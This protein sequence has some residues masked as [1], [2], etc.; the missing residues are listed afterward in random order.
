MKPALLPRGGMLCLTTDG[1]IQ[2]GAPPET[3]KDSIGSPTGVAHTFVLTRKFFDY[4][5]GMAFAEVEF[6]IYWNFFCQRRRA[7]LVCTPEQ[8]D[9][10]CAVMQESLFGP[11]H[12]D[13]RPELPAG[14]DAFDWMPDL[15][16][17]LAYFRRN[18]FSGEAL[19]LAD[20]VDFVLFDGESGQAAFDGVLVTAKDDGSYEVLDAA[21]KLRA[22]IP[23]DLRIPD[24]EDNTVT[25]STPFV[26]PVLGATILGS[27]HGFD[28]NGRTTGF[29]LWTNGRGILVDPPVDATWWLQE[30]DVP[31][32]SVDAV[33]L[34]HC[35]ADHDGG[36]LQR[37]LLAD[38]VRVYSTRTIYESF[39]RKAEAFTGLPAA[40]FAAIVEFIP[41]KI[42]EHVAINGARF[43]FHYTFHSIPTVG[44]QVWLGGK[45]LAY[46]GDTFFD[47]E[48]LAAVREQG[49]MSEGRAAQLINFPW[50]HDVV[51][52]EAGV[53]PIH[54][55]T[56]TLRALPDDVKGR[57]YLVHTTSG[58]VPDASGLRLA[59]LG[60]DGTIVLEADDH[61]QRS[62]IDVLRALR[63][64]EHFRDLPMDR[65]IEFLENVEVRRFS[66]GE[67][68]I[69]EGDTGGHFYIILSGKCAILREDTILKVIGMYEWFGE[70]SLLL[71]APR[72]ADV[73]AVSEA[74]LLSLE[75]N[76]FLGL[77]AGTPI[78][79]RM[80][81]LYSNREMATWELMDAHPV[82]AI[83]NTAQRTQL[84]SLMIREA[85]NA[86]ERL[87]VMGEEEASAFLV[88]SG[89]LREWGANG[90]SMEH[91]TA[92]L[93]GH[94][95]SIADYQPQPTTVEAV[96]DVVAFRLDMS[97]FAAFLLRYP[98]LYL[99]FLHHGGTR[100]VSSELAKEIAR[101]VS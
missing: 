68:V 38:R 45:S 85:W 1:P 48:V 74:T 94:V 67:T 83:T 44:F 77:I 49:V 14:A 27:G 73:V 76:N 78:E 75:K 12:V 84:Q 9:R 22:T 95:D 97:G 29:I 13:I 66:A 89:V 40:R 17:E 10:V 63:A 6:P 90:V 41:V 35:H 93:V 56:D 69:W 32:R 25:R 60:L 82:L 86:G 42:G 72:T 20:L 65:V 58:A 87:C 18:P 30:H 61:P 54:T 7:R 5:R 2:F 21:T 23:P 4:E 100:A 98:G 80:I 16:A 96:T 71:E 28:P 64:V 19:R 24:K 26:A 8:R 88:E 62:G 46:S 11:V 92:E 57:L 91:M 59:P 99:R 3:I 55:S 31:P 81:R 52:H 36:L 51:I 39:L 79:E 47:P 70:A 53:P 37:A 33:I 15:R 34:T 101:G 50:H 43:Q